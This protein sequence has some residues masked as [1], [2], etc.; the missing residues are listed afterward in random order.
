MKS[1]IDGSLRNDDISEESK[2]IIN[3]GTKIN[4]PKPNIT[5]EYVQEDPKN[6]H[7]S[8]M[9]NLIRNPFG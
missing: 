6:Q 3:W 5:I 2:S 4:L 7:A 1:S 9:N 8:E